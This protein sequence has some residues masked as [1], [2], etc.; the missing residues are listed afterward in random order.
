M[1][2][3]RQLQQNEQL[4]IELLLLADPDE[5]VIQS[6][7]SR[8]IGY[9][10]EIE[11][12][13]IGVYVLLPTRPQIIELVNVVVAESMQGKGLGKQLVLHAIET[14]RQL[15][16]KTIEVGTGNPG[17][18]QIGLYQKCGFRITGVDID[19]FVRHYS[20]SI[21]ENGMQCRD[22]VRM[23]QDL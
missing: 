21:Y 20:E 8:S 1:G 4:P 19:F 14:A 23:Q 11:S 13:V 16:Y 9:L 6:Y 5:Q 22:M 2:F 7:L 18:K 15:G 10:L 17:I 3:I 12:S